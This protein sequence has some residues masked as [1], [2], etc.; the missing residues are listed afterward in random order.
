MDDLSVPSGLPLSWDIEC[1][2]LFARNLVNVWIIAVR[3]VPPVLVETG[4]V[5]QNLLNLYAQ[6]CACDD[7]RH[8]THQQ[9]NDSCIQHVRVGLLFCRL[10]TISLVV[11]RRG[12]I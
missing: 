4:L 9:P 11:L 8:C 12:E 6:D 3:Y 2:L 7:Q 5:Q 10:L 1:T